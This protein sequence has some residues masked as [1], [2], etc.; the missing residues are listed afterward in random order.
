MLSKEVASIFR[1]RS[2]SHE[3]WP[4][5]FFEYLDA[6]KYEWIDPT[7]SF[8]GRDLSREQLERYLFHGGFPGVIH[9]PPEVR[10][11]ILNDYRS[12]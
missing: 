4:F 6:S 12:W 8:S 2:L 1:G 11:Q 5:D 10:R 7:K 9:E 3:I